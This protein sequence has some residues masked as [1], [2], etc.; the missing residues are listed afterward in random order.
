MKKVQL[1]L[2]GIFQLIGAGVTITIPALCIGVFFA[3][4][5]VTT[6]IVC[7][8]TTAAL[9][10]WAFILV[11]VLQNRLA[12]FTDDVCQTIDAMMQGETTPRMIFDND[13]LLDRIN[14]QLNRLY[15]MLQANKKIIEEQRADLQGMISD[16]SHQVKTPTTNLKMAAATLLEQELSREQQVEYLQSMN[17]QLDKLDFLM[18]AMVKSSRLEAGVI[19]LDKQQVPIYETLAIALGSIFLKAE[20]KHLKVTVDC[21]DDLLVPH[22]PKWTAEA[23]FNILENAVKY[24]PAEGTI[25]VA[26]VRWEA[27]T[28]IDITDTGRGI[29]ESHQATIFKRFYRE[30]EVHSIEGI[31]IGLYLTR[32]IIS[33]QNG[34]IKITSAVGTGTTFTIFLPND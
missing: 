5:N 21:P 27:C 28:K 26:V 23:L 25:Q 18:G 11:K 31:G 3:T 2:S 32:E 33:K 16:I 9:S 34:R 29:P 17:V 22:D 24:T 14:H 19:S 20:E 8:I 15:Q 6:A 7:L 13:T 1:S 10:I 30:P 4:Q 12:H